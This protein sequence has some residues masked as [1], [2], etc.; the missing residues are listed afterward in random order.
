M[1]KRNINNDILIN[2]LRL[3]LFSFHFFPQFIFCQEAS[4]SSSAS[5]DNLFNSDQANS[6]TS[7]GECLFIVTKKLI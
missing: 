3:I 6:Y 5:T 4:S 1:S 2:F 7:E